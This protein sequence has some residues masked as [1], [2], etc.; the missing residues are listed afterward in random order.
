MDC[1]V[2][3]STHS[4][5]AWSK[6]P[7]WYQSASTMKNWLTETSF[8]SSSASPRWWRALAAP[9]AQSGVCSTQATVWCASTSTSHSHY[10]RWS[11]RTTTSTKAEPWRPKAHQSVILCSCRERCPSVTTPSPCQAPRS[12]WTRLRPVSPFTEQTSSLRIRDTSLKTFPDTL[13][14]VS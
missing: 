4:W 13:S 11:T 6:T 1:W 3:L 10:E 9:S 2:W 7:S 5:T 14:M 8:T 12:C